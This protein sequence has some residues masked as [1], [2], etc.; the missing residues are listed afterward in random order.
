MSKIVFIS[1][2]GKDGLKETDPN[3]YIFNTLYNTFQIISEGLLSS[4]TV[5]AN[6]TTFT[7]AHN[8]GYVPAVYAFIK[9]S[10]GYVTLPDGKERADAHPVERYWNVEVDSTN[11]YFVVYKGASA[12]YN[13]SIKYYIFE[14]VEI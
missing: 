11:I 1:K 2:A 12:N 3:D 8:L 4:Q 6:P 5:S 14:G 10:D 13:V 9:F 7:V